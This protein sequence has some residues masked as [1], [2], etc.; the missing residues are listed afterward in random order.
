MTFKQI[1]TAW[2]LFKLGFKVRMMKPGKKYTYLTLLRL[3]T[4]LDEKLSSDE[5]KA[6]TKYIDKIEEGYDSVL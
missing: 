2:F 3:N 6:F 1:K 4:I 5:K